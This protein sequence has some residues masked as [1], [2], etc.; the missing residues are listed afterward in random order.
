[1]ATAS[2]GTSHNQ[3][4]YTIVLTANETSVDTVNNKS[5]VSVKLELKSTTK[6]F[7]DYMS[8]AYISV[9][10][11]EKTRMEKSLECAF[12]S[13]LTLCSWSGDIYH[14]SDGTKTV[15][16]LGY[17]KSPKSG[18]K[19]QYSAGEAT[20]SL[21]LNLSNIPRESKIKSMTSSVD[22]GD[23]IYISVNKSVSS[24]YH[25][26]SITL[27][28]QTVTSSA[29]SESA[30]LQVPL[31]WCS[32]I[33]TNP[34]KKTNV[35]CRVTT[36]TNQSCSTQVGN[37]QYGFVTIC[38]PE[39]IVPEI[40]NFS[41]TPYNPS[42]LDSS[43]SSLYLQNVTKARVNATVVEKYGSETSFEV[44]DGISSKTKKTDDK[45]LTDTL[46]ASGTRTVT[47][48]VTDTRGR[49]ASQSAS[50]NVLQYNLPMISSYSAVRVSKIGEEYVYD[51][52]GEY[53]RLNCSA[54]ISPIS[55]VTNSAV[56]SAYING[57][58]FSLSSG[59]DYYTA[60]TYSKNLSH[61]VTFRVTDLTGIVS[62]VDV[63]VSESK[64]ALTF[65]KK[66][67]GY[68][69]E[70][71]RGAVP[72]DL[73]VN[74]KIKLPD[75]SSAYVPISDF[76]S[77]T[78]TSGVWNYRKWNGGIIEL[79]TKSLS[80]TIAW[81]QYG[82][83]YMSPFD[84]ISVPLVTEILFVSGDAL[85]WRHYNW[86]SATVKSESLAIAI[87]YYSVNTNGDGET[88]NFQAY[89]IGKWK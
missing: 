89:V 41:V 26:A 43:I 6:R 45:I 21:S 84:N 34:P 55:G 30:L 60:R 53:I 52:E 69:A 5:T 19:T 17:F 4:Y 1:M 85:Y 23:N 73:K 83:L 76:V 16:V 12:N 51:D 29:F 22:A 54:A 3:G 75:S 35:P 15:S 20:V 64:S 42:T 44:S 14:S 11:A 57:E 18:N 61:N 78:G 31:D 46:T 80:H 71:F 39:N 68:D 24:Y 40:N 49:S 28:G 13:T 88:L 74:G 10:G 48:K 72:G 56:I 66:T 62:S 27:N 33:Q 77:E 37:T 25:K 65:E 79:W 58:Q 81:E 63:E 50:I 2:Q 9:D 47:F 36:Y 86:S 8:V 70:F 59:V 38:V 67:G 82:S 87:R 7:A 32:F